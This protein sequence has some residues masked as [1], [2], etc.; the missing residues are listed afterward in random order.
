MRQ[1]LVLPIVFV[2]LIVS[3][4]AQS[5]PIPF[6]SQPLVPTSVSPG[7]PALTLTVNGT[8]FTSAAV[9]NWNGSPLTTTYISSIQLAATVPPANIAKPQTVN[10]TVTN[11]A[12]GGGTSRSILFTV[13]PSTASL[14][15]GTSLLNVGLGPAAIV[16]GDF[17]N[18][19]KTDLAVVNTTQPDE[20]CYQGYG[21]GTIQILVG[22]GTGGFSTTSNTCLVESTEFYAGAGGLPFLD[23]ED[24]T[25]DGKLG[26][27][28]ESYALEE[29][30]NGL[31]T[32]VGNGDGTLSETYAKGLSDSD[33]TIFPAFAD[34][35][36]DGH[37]DFIYTSDDS[38]YPGLSVF[39]GNGDGTFA[40]CYP[41][42][43]V[44]VSGTG[45][46]A[47]DFNRDGVLDLAVISYENNASY[48]SSPVGILLGVQGG[49]FVEAS[50]QPITDLNAGDHRALTVADFNGDGILDLAF[51]PSGSSGLTILDGNGDGTFTQVS[52]EPSSGCVSA[53]SIA[54][55]DLN[56]DGKLDLV[57]VTG[58]NTIGIFLG[59]GDGTFQP[60]LSESVGNGPQAVAIGDFNGDG[61]LDIAVAN[62]ADN[63]VTIL[64][65]T[66]GTTTVVSSTADS[67]AFGQSITLSAS[68]TPVNG[69]SATGTVT[70]FDTSNTLGS[71][72]LND[73]VA[74]LSAIVLGTGSHT[75]TASYA[76]GDSVLGSTS[77]PLIE[78]VNPAATATSLFSGANPVALNQPVAFTATISS[79]YGGVATGTVAFYDGR[80]QIGSGQV[81]NNAAMLTIESLSIGNHPITASYSGDS[82][83]FGSM[84]N[85]VS[86]VVAKATTTTTL[87]S[88]I[89][90]LVAGKSVTFTATVSS[91]ASSRTG[92]VQFLNGTALL[93][94]VTLKSGTAKYT[95]SQLPPGTDA[96]TA[97]YS[98]DSNNS[99]G[100]SALVNQLVQA[101]TTTTLTSSPESSAYGQSVIFT[102]VVTSS[103][104][105]PSDGETITFKQGSTVLGTGTLSSGVAS[106]SVSTLGVGDKAITA[107]YG[108][109]AN[110]TSSKSEVLS[111]VVGVA[112]TT[113]TLISSANSSN[114]KQSVTFT[115]TVV[116]QF[117]STV[118]GSVTFMDGATKLKTVN[119]SGG[120]AKY[121]T[122]T[123][124]VGTHDITATYNG[125]ADFTSSSEAVTQTVN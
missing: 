37:L 34:F 100:S 81:T 69:G 2:G 94:T 46:F 10:I 82:N 58:A 31:Q 23:A 36:N 13:T 95:T 54:V 64:L 68:V 90:P 48:T 91:L 121:A 28:A 114:Y 33:N 40:C 47:G 78:T 74:T 24:F 3:L 79:Q 71:A 112:M 87:L 105:P 32:Y 96:I 70:F 75:I 18:D 83:F 108:G 49:S 117:G 106:V 39:M 21:E 113:T 104:G 45:V 85:T 65:Q 86:Q 7:S 63:T 43:S 15:F 122:S 9:V 93:A 98:G 56:G 101:P 4:H 110:F 5:N 6:L 14:T 20:S 102:G 30:A 115:A 62:L 89:N 60:A 125:N 76:G 29:E 27:A 50:T 57:C 116:S 80:T 103:I 26:V 16:A 119:L 1:L 61:R 97:V 25:G 53:P 35:N 22:D 84:S 88:S 8:G 44:P 77:A 99:G 12:P 17:N 11:P 52:G 41:G 59:N 55:A 92:T 42:A 124:V 67:V 73:N 38:A 19:G 111:Q 123:L 72:S 120:T 109:D 118:T 107:V 66:I 51:A